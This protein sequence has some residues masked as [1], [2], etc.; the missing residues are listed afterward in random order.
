[1]TVGVG[2]IVTELPPVGKVDRN[3]GVQV[4]VRTPSQTWPLAIH[5]CFCHHLTYQSYVGS[6]RLT[7]S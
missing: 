7:L 4:S 2:S 5:F 3:L 1:M 6:L